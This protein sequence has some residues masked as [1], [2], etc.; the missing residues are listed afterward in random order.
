MKTDGYILT[1]ELLQWRYFHRPGGGT[2]AHLR[3]PV[4]H[5]Q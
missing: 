1:P 2:G 3:A 4:C 5:P